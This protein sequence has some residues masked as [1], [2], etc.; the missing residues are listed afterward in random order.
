[1]LAHQWGKQERKNASQNQNVRLAAYSFDQ[2]GYSIL[3][4]DTSSEK[5]LNS[6]IV[7]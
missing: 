2:S 7:V 6:L 5:L 1:M 3:H 4:F